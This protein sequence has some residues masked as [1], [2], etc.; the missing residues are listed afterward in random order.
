MR[1]DV[2]FTTSQSSFTLA[3]IPDDVADGYPPLDQL[4]VDTAIQDL[5]P[6]HQ[7][8]AGVIAFEHYVGQQVTHSRE[9]P[10]MVEQ[11]IT[12]FFE[13]RHVSAH[14][15]TDVPGRVWPSSGTLYVSEYDQYLAP[16]MTPTGNPHDYYVQVADGA[17]FNGALASAHQLIIASNAPSISRLRPDT[18]AKPGLYTAV[19][20]LLSRDLHVRNIHITTD[21][22][23][24]DLTRYRSLLRSIDLNLSWNSTSES[25]PSSQHVS[26]GSPILAR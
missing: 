12:A 21:Q 5:T 16:P 2:G 3:A 4:V 10:R 25:S 22:A 13:G 6:A 9:L 17:M 24:G 19:A 14:P 7:V 23:A 1:F 18:F 26:I 8:V 15:V 20:V 11:A